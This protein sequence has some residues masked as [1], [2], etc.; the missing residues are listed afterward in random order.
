MECLLAEAGKNTIRVFCNTTTV[1]QEER[2]R[3]RN[4]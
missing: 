3:K 4:D 2:R 1:A